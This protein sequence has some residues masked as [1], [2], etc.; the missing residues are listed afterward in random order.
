MESEDLFVFRSDAIVL[1]SSLEVSSV[2]FSSSSPAQTH[3]RATRHHNTTAVTCDGDVSVEP[4]PPKQSADL[5]PQTEKREERHKHI[6]Q[7][8]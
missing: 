1:S 3:S 2:Y 6:P 8:A 5:E 7:P 4:E